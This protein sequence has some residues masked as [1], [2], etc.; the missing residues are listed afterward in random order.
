MGLVENRVRLKD[1]GSLGRDDVRLV[2]VASTS[3]KPQRLHWAAAQAF[4]DLRE[5][6]ERA[7]YTLKIASGWRPKKRQSRA[8]FNA[9]LERQYGSV[10]AGRVW[11]AYSSPHET[12]LAFDLG[13]H[14][15][16][17]VSATAG[18]QRRKPV[19][20]WLVQNA[21]RYGITPYLAEPWHWEVH[22]PKAT[23]D[24]SSPSTPWL[25]VLGVLGAITA[26]W[27]VA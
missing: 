9:Q 18:A 6:A 15:L 5:A 3:S 24:R 14:G 16:T 21:H 26:I 8:S 25:A 17:P 12:G 19:Y 11:R 4:N 2:E 22:V 20:A 10:S 13:T 23:W 27:W 7:G 1:Y